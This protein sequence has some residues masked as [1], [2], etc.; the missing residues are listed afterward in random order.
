MFA[1]LESEQLPEATTGHDADG[2]SSTPRSRSMEKGRRSSTLVTTKT[3]TVCQ[4]VL[5]EEEEVCSDKPYP[6]DEPSTATTSSGELANAPGTYTP[7]PAW[8]WV[9]GGHYNHTLY[10][11]YNMQSAGISNNAWP[12]SSPQF[13][14]W[15]MP[16]ASFS[17][18]ALPNNVANA[19][20][21]P[22][23]SVS[24]MGYNTVPLC[25]LWSGD[26]SMPLGDHLTP[27]TQEKI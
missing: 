24:N 6:M 12:C 3:V 9:G 25:A 20:V 23:L 19:G 17:L 4:E 14:G 15:G 7:V 5:D 22:Y 18:P 10:T 16:Y 13:S 27:A 26:Y 1:A 8:P 21:W 2:A 11:P